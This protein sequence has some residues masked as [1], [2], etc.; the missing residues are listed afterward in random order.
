MTVTID[1]TLTI[2]TTNRTLRKKLER[3][4]RAEHGIEDFDFR[5]FRASDA[6]KEKAAEI[7]KRQRDKALR[8]RAHQRHKAATFHTRSTGRSGK[9]R[10]AEQL[11]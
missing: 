2:T 9:H 8:V 6:G 4:H 3:E 11:E 5:A 7:A 10:L 1:N